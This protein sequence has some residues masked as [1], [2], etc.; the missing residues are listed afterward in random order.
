MQST[1]SSQ[2]I[3]GLSRITRRRHVI[4]NLPR[5]SARHLPHW[6]TGMRLQWKVWT[7]LSWAVKTRRSCANVWLLKRKAR[8]HPKSS[9]GSIHPCRAINV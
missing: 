3:T 1:G 2:R 6:R 5:N 7:P 4:V 8:W 9:P